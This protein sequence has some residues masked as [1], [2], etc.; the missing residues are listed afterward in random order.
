MPTPDP[1]YIGSARPGPQ[2]SSLDEVSDTQRTSLLTHANEEMYKQNLEL[3]VRNKTLNALRTLY[4][5]TMSSLAVDDVSQRMS[6]AI[7]TELSFPLV[8]I[9]A[10]S[11]DQKTLRFAGVTKSPEIIKALALLG[12]PLGE[13]LIP[14]DYPYNLL[15]NAIKQKE[16]LMTG[17]LLDV[18]APLVTQDTA[19]EI[20][21]Q[22]KIKTMIIYPL[23][24]GG[25]AVGAL[26][27]GL[28]KKVDDMTRAQRETLEELIN[29]V[30]IS[31]ERAQLYSDLKLANQQLQDLDKLKDE[32]VSL[33]SHELRTPMTA[34]RGSLTTILDGYA[35]EISKEA[36]EF[37][38]AANTENDRLI[39]LVNNLLNISR[40]EAG[41]FQFT[42]QPTDLDALVAEV[43][44]NLQM[45]AKDKNITLSYE[46]DGTIPKVIADGDK[47]KEVFINLI[48]NAVKFTH[49]G[50]VTVGLSKHQGIV[51]CSVADT[52]SGIAKEDQDLLFKKFSQ[53]QGD[54]A[55]QSGGTGLGLYICKQIVEGHHG[56]IW[57]ESTL[58]VG[59]TF[60]FSLP[61]SQ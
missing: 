2:S 34:I 3:S 13:S 39:R 38:T 22:S 58:G 56:K 35:G 23:L 46:R 20:G 37:L 47:I 45:A 21:R 33:A 12:K 7:V 9:S 52:G 10:V 5:I 41:R 30:G 16:R 42:M 50:G 24:F 18:F 11:A 19:D 61:I 31:I 4:A 55:K 59:S 49:K 53:V 44:N 51:I 57:L 14:M 28:D 25:K 1:V 27:I 15:V 8:M 60:F 36:R 29:V 43:V 48:G 26:S 40:I 6:D 32:F 17:N 54:Y